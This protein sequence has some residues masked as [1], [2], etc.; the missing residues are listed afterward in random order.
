MEK[1]RKIST[2][3][4]KDTFVRSF[5]G[6]SFKQ[7]ASATFQMIAGEILLP[8]PEPLFKQNMV[9]VSLGRG[10]NVTS[11]AYPGAFI[12]PI[13]GN[14]HGTYEGP[15]PGQMVMVGFENGN[16]NA[17]FV[18]NKYP[19]Q[20]GGNTL[21]EPSYLNPL[22]RNLYDSTDVMIGHFSGSSL[23]FNTGILSGEI[24]GSVTF[25][26][27]TSM[28]IIA[29]TTILLD[30][31][32]SAE[33][34]SLIVKLTGATSVQ[35]NGNTNF[36]V[37]YT[38]LKTAFD[39]LRTEL[40]SLITM[41]NTHIHITTATVGATATPGILSPTVLQGTPAVADMSAAQNLKVLM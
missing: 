38:E 16:S 24:P 2:N 30:S 36:A 12:D 23:V 32:I 15:I 3:R 27:T 14:L 39:L 21:F 37:K 13:S 6:N 40:N 33:V 28:D 4:G 20:G 34:S 8:E 18:V 9:T 10:G 5:Q 7:Q 22:T 35:L 41:Y 25:S 17:P 26:A 19:Y 29:N 11:V 1:Q 31:L